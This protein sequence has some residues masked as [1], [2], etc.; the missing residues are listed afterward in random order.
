MPNALG[1]R[2]IFGLEVY[3]CMQKL[4]SCA[5]VNAWCNLVTDMCRQI[6]VDAVAGMTPKTDI[7]AAA[8]AAAVW[9]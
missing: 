4:P 6:C 7:F 9:C 2:D 1:Y 3:K 8:A 5:S